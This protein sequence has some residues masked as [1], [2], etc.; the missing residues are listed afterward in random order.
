MGVADLKKC[1]RGRGT[2][3]DGPGYLREEGGKEEE[4]LGEEGDVLGRARD[5][6]GG[7]G[8]LGE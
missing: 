6:V 1:L 8:E 2:A 4:K 5:A 3:P 7:E